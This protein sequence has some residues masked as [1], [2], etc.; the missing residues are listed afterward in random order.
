MNIR[1]AY[2]ADKIY[3]FFNSAQTEAS[4]YERVIL[5]HH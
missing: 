2:A 4:G 3:E 1:C 5:A